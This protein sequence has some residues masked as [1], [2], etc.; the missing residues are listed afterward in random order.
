M[1]NGKTASS[2]APVALARVRA[3]LS[4]RSRTL[5]DNDAAPRRR[6]FM[7]PSREG[8]F[9]VQPKAHPNLTC[10]RQASITLAPLKNDGQQ[11][12]APR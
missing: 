11:E 5:S 7:G 10:I 4:S 2:P 9:W 1:T 12:A 6:I 3:S 8:A